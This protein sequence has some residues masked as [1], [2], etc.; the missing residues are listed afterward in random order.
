[1]AF[2]LENSK[3]YPDGDS[4]TVMPELPNSSS[5]Q[6]SDRVF[7]YGTLQPGQRYYQPYCAGFVIATQRAIAHGNLYH[8]PMGYP[9]MTPGDRPIQGYCLTF[10]DPEVLARL[11]QLEGY[12]PG[13]SPQENEYQRETIEVFHPDG[14]SLGFVWI[15]R[16]STERAIALGGVPYPQL[17]WREGGL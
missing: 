7:V 10:A 15:Y 17:V 16:M 5:L 14:P 8:L 4:G 2:S 12:Q 6:G 13:R 3:M 9:A 1:M 11:D